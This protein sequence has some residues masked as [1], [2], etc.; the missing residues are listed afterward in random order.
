LPDFLKAPTQKNTDL[1]RKKAGGLRDQAHSAFEDNRKGE[2][3]TLSQ[4]AKK[5]D[6][7]AMRS[8][9]Y[10]QKPW[11]NT[12][13]DLHGLHVDEAIEF[14]NWYLDHHQQSGHKEVHIITGAGNHSENNQSRVKEETH[15]ILRARGL[16]FEAENHGK[17][18]VQL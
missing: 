1:S 4:E 8:I 14:V 10:P 17:V 16:K 13:A 12:E 3:H 2:A 9:L 7:E 15:K 6:R 5:Y 11:T 18:L